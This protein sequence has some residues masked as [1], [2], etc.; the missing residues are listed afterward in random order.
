MMRVRERH[1]LNPSRVMKGR[2][3]PLCIY[4]SRIVIMKAF[5][6][7][8][9]RLMGRPGW[10]TRYPLFL[11]DTLIVGREDVGGRCRAD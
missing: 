5:G 9:D 10:F 8:T 1:I 7:K 6:I 3:Y 2:L 11:G 4:G